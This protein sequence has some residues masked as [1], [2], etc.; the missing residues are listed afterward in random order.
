VFT[1]VT[2]F[3]TA[4]N[5]PDLLERTLS[6]L[7][8]CNLK[9]LAVIVNGINP[10]MEEVINRHKRLI[11]DVITSKENRGIIWAVNVG[12]EIAKFN[13]SKFVNYIQDDVVIKNKDFLK[14]L[15]R[16]WRLYKQELNLGA[17]SGYHYSFPP[18]AKN[19]SH[20]RVY[21]EIKR[22][23]TLFLRNLLQAQNLF[24]PLEY[25]KEHF[26][27]SYIDIDGYPRGLPS[28]RRGSNLE[29]WIFF[30][31]PKAVRKV[32][33][34]CATIDLMEHIGEDKSTWR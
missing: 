27:I 21:R 10:Q 2:T 34:T 14:I 11:S 24:M 29:Y 12:V 8:G 3:I 7:E 18:D 4:Y 25:W 9:Y 1:K 32:G 33:R 16:A 6:S 23:H 22:K 20:K 31:S 28:N 5:R 19:H 13:G 30:H 26:P 17:L 15:L